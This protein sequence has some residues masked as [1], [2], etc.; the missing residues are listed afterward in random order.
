MLSRCLLFHFAVLL[1]LKSLTFQAWAQTT[2]TDQDLVAAA[3]ALGSK[4]TTIKC[5]PFIDP[6]C[7][8]PVPRSEGPNGC[9]DCKP[10]SLL[11]AL[12]SDDLLIQTE[13]LDIGNTELKLLERRSNEAPQLFSLPGN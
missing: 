5:N 13:T 3:K 8:V 11:D 4:D 6:G 9:T 2:Y 10:S 12:R 1:V 7:H